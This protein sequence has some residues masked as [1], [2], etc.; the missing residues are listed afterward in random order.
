MAGVYVH[1]PFC[2]SRCIYCN[3]F[4]TTGKTPLLEEQY[5]D[6]LHK[7]LSLRRNY[8]RSERITT[9]YIGG[10][11]PSLLSPHSIGRIAQEFSDLAEFTV[12]CNPDDVTPSFAHS[13]VEMGVNRV[14]MGVQTFSNARLAFLHRRHN[15][16]QIPQAIDSL[17]SA[18]I[19]NIS[20]DLI[21][22]FPNQSLSQWQQ[23]ID[24]AVSLSVP[25][26]SAY[27]LSYEEGTPLWRMLSQG[28]VTALADDACREMYET[29]LDAMNAAGYDH[30]EISNFAIP[31]H[32][33]L[34]NSNYWNGTP[35]LGIGAGAHSYSG[36]PYP[37]EVIWT[38]GN[39]V[40]RQ[41]NVSNVAEYIRSIQQGVIPCETEYLDRDTQYNDMITTSL[42]T[43]AGICIDA[44][45]D[46][47]R[48]YV[49]TQ[50]QKHISNGLLCMDAINGR[51]FLHL[52][53]KG[54]FVS[55]DIMSDL[56]MI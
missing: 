34:H 48:G 8:L 47:Y 19:Y 46:P 50:S 4:S 36:S 27:S 22:G 10:G 17:R 2:K 53:R 5:I 52:S 28:K 25:H 54:L 13:L 39:N 7:E 31:G 1:I 43:A 55:D 3:F 6:S 18:G 21:F 40:S 35:Y 24:C 41:W 56:I 23:D 14:S 33:A 11:T 45:T 20:I 29:L 30:Y 32:H 51:R 38:G 37:K 26:I 42:R 15:A 49:L 16:S 12:E 44:L 9:L